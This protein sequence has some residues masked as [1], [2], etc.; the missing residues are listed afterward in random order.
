MNPGLS[1]RRADVALTAVGASGIVAIFAPF[2]HETSPCSALVD[3]TI[4]WPLAVA[5]L[6][7]APIF[8]AD[9]IW[10][11]SG[12]LT[13]C[14]RTTLYGGAA[15]SAAM[16]LLWWNF[17]YRPIWQASVGNWVY[18]AR[19]GLPIVALGFGLALTAFH[20]VRGGDRGLN[21]IMAAQCAYIANALL[22]LHDAWQGFMEGP[23]YANWGAGAYFT[24]VACICYAAQISRAFRHRLVHAGPTAG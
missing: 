9:V 6:L 3:G 7:A 23:G 8:I 10:L 1:A 2:Y 11:V 13:R 14:V 20:L 18:L 22:A 4:E 24:I 19:T 17:M 16:T 21:S 12:R 15:V 5:F